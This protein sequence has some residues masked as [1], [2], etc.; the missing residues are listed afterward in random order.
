MHQ[1]FALGEH[2]KSNEKLKKRLFAFAT[3][4]G[5]FYAGTF[6]FADVNYK[7]AGTFGDAFGFANALFSGG[8]LVMLIYAVIL[9]REELA[10]IKEERDDTRKLLSGQE[11]INA[12]QEEALRKQIF[13]QSFASL[14]KLAAE[15][16]TRLSDAAA[17]GSG[18][19]TNPLSVAGQQARRRF[20]AEF[21]LSAEPNGLANI[22]KTDFLLSLLTHIDD[23]ISSAEISDADRNRLG[24]LLTSFIDSETAICFVW[25]AIEFRLRDKRDEKLEIFL[26]SR[27]VLERISAQH[28]TKYIEFTS[29]NQ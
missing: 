7:D 15:E 13:E 29:G 18:G 12:L 3:F 28:R 16:K 9:Q 24:H 11:R 27:G 4:C 10:V 25:K 22:K 19:S 20:G 6:L 2:M 5:L 14:L 26:I 8:A 1:R 21:S 17:Y 23:L